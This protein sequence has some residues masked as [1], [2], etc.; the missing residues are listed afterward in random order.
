[1]VATNSSAFGCVLA[2]A[3]R[4]TGSLKRQLRL[5]FS[6]PTISCGGVS[7]YFIPVLNPRCNGLSPPGSRRIGRTRCPGKHAAYQTPP[8]RKFGPRSFARHHLAGAAAFPLAARVRANRLKAGREASTREIHAR[9]VSGSSRAQAQ[10]I[11]YSGDCS[12]VGRTL[13]TLVLK[14]PADDH[15]LEWG[16]RQPRSK[17]VTVEVIPRRLSKLP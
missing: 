14:Y 15:A 11:E 6:E 9:L 1:M 3:F 12:S 2:P 4:F 8:R 16:V 17:A 10:P 13:A 5:P 7:S